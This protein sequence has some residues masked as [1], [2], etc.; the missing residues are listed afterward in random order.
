MPVARHILR[1][2]RL[3]VPRSSLKPSAPP[4]HRAGV[5]YSGDDHGTLSAFLSGSCLSTC[6]LSLTPRPCRSPLSICSSRSGSNL[7]VVYLQD[8]SV[9]RSL[10]A[11]KGASRD[12]ATRLQVETHGSTVQAE[13]SFALYVLRSF[14]LGVPLPCSLA[15]TPQLT[16]HR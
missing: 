11:R 13:L 3:N 16:V 5:A 6:L 7:A 12:R 2:G 15:C 4:L 10:T 14:V 1:E 8:C 9:R